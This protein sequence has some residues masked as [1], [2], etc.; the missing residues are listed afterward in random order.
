[1]CLVQANRKSYDVYHSVHDNF[2]WISRFADP[3][4]SYHLAMALV[5]S[6]LA[7]ALSTT[8]LLPF[9]PRDYAGAMNRIYKN[10]EEEY[11]ELLEAQN[12]SLGMYRRKC[13]MGN[14]VRVEWFIH[15]Y[16]WVY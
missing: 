6:D 15:C 12:I 14:K 3:T 4:F 10:L 11:G 9:D 5:W 13:C 2:D 1:M 8:P 7:I 16:K